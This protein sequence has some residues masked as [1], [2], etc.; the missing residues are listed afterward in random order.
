MHS[1][2]TAVRATSRSHGPPRRS[3]D[4]DSYLPRT[5]PRASSSPPTS[6]SFPSGVSLSDEPGRASASPD[7]ASSSDTPAFCAIWRDLARAQGLLDLVAGDRRVVALADPG[8]KLVV[9]TCG[10]QLAHDPVQPAGR[11]KEPF[12][13]TENPGE[14]ATLPSEHPHQ[15]IR[16]THGLSFRSWKSPESVRTHRRWAPTPFVRGN[17]PVRGGQPGGVRPLAAC[18]RFVTLSGE[19]R[20]DGSRFV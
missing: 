2:E 19:C 15:L 20:C 5:F 8:L 4:E 1:S 17:P 3:C 11:A 12:D 6:G 10:L 16:E 7:A 13:L 18:D 9:E 14:I